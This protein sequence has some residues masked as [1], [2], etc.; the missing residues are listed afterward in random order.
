M[1]TWQDPILSFWISIIGP[2]VVVVL[3]LFPWRIVLGSAGLILFGP[4]NW[5]FRVIRER[6]GIPPPDMDTIIKRKM[7]HPGDAEMQGLEEPL[8]C[9]ATDENRSLDYS[10]MDQTNVKHIAVPY[11]QLMYNHRFYDWPPENEFARV[12]KEDPQLKCN[13]QNDVTDS[14]SVQT[15]KSGN[16][17]ERSWRPTGR[18]SPRRY[19]KKRA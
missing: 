5:M 16:T 13:Q 17:K 7:Q 9:N 18:L 15:S 12:L 10:A 6:K 8:F 19:K 2:V 1:F 3:H 14:E 4:Q 11:S